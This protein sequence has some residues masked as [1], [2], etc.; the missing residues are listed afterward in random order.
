MD[1]VRIPIAAD[2]ED[3]LAWV[4]AWVR[5]FQDVQQVTPLDIEGDSLESGAAL[6]HVYLKG[7]HRIQAWRN[8]HNQV[9]RDCD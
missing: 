7:I 1:K 5:M 6:R 8:Q 3:A 2:D 4:T 9:R